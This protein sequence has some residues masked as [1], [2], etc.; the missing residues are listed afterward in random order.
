ML[1]DINIKYNII[2]KI[3]IAHIIIVCYLFNVFAVNAV[4]ALRPIT[5]GNDAEDKISYEIQRSLVL[6]NLRPAERPIAIFDSGKGGLSVL[7]EI[8]ALLPNEDKIYVADTAYLPYGSKSKLAITRRVINIVNFFKFK[9][10]KIIIVACGSAASMLNENIIETIDPPVLSYVKV[11]AQEAINATSNG[12]IGVIATKLTFLSGSYAEEITQLNPNF[13]VYT[14]ALTTEVVELVEN[15]QVDNIQKL[16]KLMEA[17]LISLKKIG[18]DTLILGCSH[19][20][21]LT[22]SI[23]DI[24]GNDI[25][26]INPAKAVAKEVKRILQK[27]GFLTRKTNNAIP[28]V[29]TT[30]Y[31]ARFGKKAYDL[32]GLS[33]SVSVISNIKDAQNKLQHKIMIEKAIKSAA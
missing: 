12:K 4:W 27:E 26:I 22:K 30:S 19:Y 8:E 17:E 20:T 24:I 21:F 15:G 5:T 18:I 11:A 31:S 6:N 33:L 1:K 9:D 7:K 2:S 14:K 29:M 32:I 25:T 10:A 13:K 16:R 3:I 28:K 23:K